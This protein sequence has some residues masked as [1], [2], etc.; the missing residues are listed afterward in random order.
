[1]SGNLAVIE[2]AELPT[3][4]GEGGC[5]LR[6]LSVYFGISARLATASYI[7]L[8]P[9]RVRELKRLRYRKKVRTRDPSG[10]PDDVLEH[11]S[12][13]QE[14]GTLERAGRKLQSAGHTIYQ[15]EDLLQ[16][17]IDG[18]QSNEQRELPV[19][20]NERLLCSAEELATY[21]VG[22]ARF[23]D[24]QLFPNLEPAA[25]LGAH[26]ALG[27][28]SAQRRALRQQVEVDEPFAVREVIQ[29]AA[30]R[31]R[32]PDGVISTLGGLA[33]GRHSNPDDTTDSLGRLKEGARASRHDIESVNR[34]Q[35]DRR[36]REIEGNS[37]D[38]DD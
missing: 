31:L 23:E 20:A 25:H 35:V 30:E 13:A 36:L 4:T 5:A 21:I 24:E 6:R 18:I 7:G 12:L 2:T 27:A 8:G 9:S 14:A 22:Y 10:P 11:G 1:M 26:R 15:V 17:T 38:D 32:G 29:R 16:D 3:I 37:A 34:E 19:I 33:G 28:S